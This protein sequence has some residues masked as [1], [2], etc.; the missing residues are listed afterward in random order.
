MLL[1]LLDIFINNIAPILVIAGIG[2]IIGKRFE[3]DPRSLGKLTFNVFS[4]A[5]VFSAL[6]HSALRPLELGQIALAVGMY[7]ALLAVMSYSVIRWRVQ[8]QLQRVSVLLCALTGNNGNYGLPLI[9]LAF[10]DEV[11]ARAV[12]VFVAMIFV[13]YTFGVFVASS[14]RRSTREA[15]TS[16]MRVPLIYAALAGLVVNQLHIPIPLALDR[17][18]TLMADGAFPTM[19]ILLGIQLSRVRLTNY[20]TVALGVGLRMLAAPLAALAVA[21]ILGLPEFIL[22]AVIVQASMPVAVNT[23]VLAMEFELDSEQISGAVLVSTLLSPVTLSFI[24][25]ALRQWSAGG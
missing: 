11:L 15:L 16:I 23:T 1:E 21:L 25:L 24:I 5:L 6:S 2:F 14:G 22:I 18:L 9:T 3:L 7:T 20:G 13:T 8:G 4:P 10:G 17:S 19:L 12:M